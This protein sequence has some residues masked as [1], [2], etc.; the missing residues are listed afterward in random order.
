MDWSPQQEKALAL[1]GEW[2]ERPKKQ[3][4]YLAGYAGTGKSTLARHLSANVSGRVA[5]GAFTGKAAL[6]MRSMGCRDATTIHSMLYVPYDKSTV[7]LRQLESELK[8][9]TEEPVDHAMWEPKKLRKMI[10]AERERLKQPGFELKLNADVRNSSLIVVDEVSMIDERMGID[11]EGLGVP[12]LVLGD[13]AQLPP[14]KGGG[15]FT[16]RT[17]DFLLTEVHRHAEGSGIVELATSIRAGR[18]PPRGDYHGSRIIGKSGISVEDLLKYDQVLVGRNATRQRLNSKM[19]Q[20]LGRTS[21]YPV[22]GDRLV[23]LQNDHDAG[24]LNGGLFTVLEDAEGPDDGIMWIHIK[25]DFDGRKRSVLAHVHPFEGR[26]DE[27]VGWQRREAQLFDFGYALTVHKA[28][29]SQWPRVCVVDESR[30]FPDHAQRWLYTA[31]TRA[32]ESVDIVDVNDYL[33]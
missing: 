3:V 14:V 33:K 27:L 4:F 31:V 26:L 23:C 13:P 29:G 17:P 12:I 8:R 10:A 24:L 5:F 6:V 9:I 20:S 22:A 30:C 11:L 25:D 18:R 16:S 32:Q 1:V 2:I 28:Q 19:R 21:A 7:K 15:Y